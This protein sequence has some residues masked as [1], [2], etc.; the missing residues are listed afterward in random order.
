M[1][2]THSIWLTADRELNRAAKAATFVRLSIV[3]QY[4]LHGDRATKEA[5]QKN[6]TDLLQHKIPGL[7]D[8][9]FRYWE[10]VSGL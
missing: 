5:G 8:A 1:A 3:H 6:R 7:L 4:I 10:A 2:I 9:Q